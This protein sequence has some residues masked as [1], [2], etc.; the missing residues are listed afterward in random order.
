ML[1]CACLLPLLKK[2]P[3]MVKKRQ[4]LV[5]D[6]HVHSEVIKD[7]LDLTDEADAYLSDYS[8]QV[9]QRS[10]K[11]GQPGKSAHT[12]FRIL[13]EAC[14]ALMLLFLGGGS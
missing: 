3:Q 1:A 11:L 10:T 14:F 9:N 13:K 6:L 5:D 2:K 12:P 4:D 7:Q 8:E